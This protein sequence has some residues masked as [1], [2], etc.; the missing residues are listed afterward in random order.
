MVLDSPFIGDRFLVYN[1]LIN[2]K[3]WS[4]PEFLIHNPIPF[5]LTDS[6][7]VFLLKNKYNFYPSNYLFHEESFWTKRVFK[8]ID[9]E[10]IFNKN[11]LNV[12]ALSEFEDFR[13]FVVKNLKHPKFDIYLDSSFSKVIDPSEVDSNYIKDTRWV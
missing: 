6:E 13:N 9:L 2:Y 8:T 3:I 4:I 1:G 11:L 12:S 10:N 5:S 7:R